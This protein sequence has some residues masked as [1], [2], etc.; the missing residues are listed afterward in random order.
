MKKVKKRSQFKMPRMMGELRRLNIEWNRLVEAARE[1]GIRRVEIPELGR[2]VRV[3]PRS[4]FQMART[5]A[6]ARVRR[7]Q[8]TIAPFYAPDL[9]SVAGLRTFG[10]EIEAI[11]PL[12]HGTSSIAHSILQEGIMCQAESLNHTTRNYWKVTTDGSVSGQGGRGLEIVSPALSGEAGFDQLRKVCSVLNRLGAKINFSCGLHVHVGRTGSTPTGMKKLVKLQVKYARIIDAFMAPSRRPGGSRYCRQVQV[13]NASLLES[14]TTLNDVAIAVGQLSIHDRYKTINFRSRQP[15][16]E[17]RQHQGT[18][19][20]HKIEMWTRFCIRAM[21][22]ME[23][24]EEIQIADAPADLNG[25]MELIGATEA[26][27]NYFNERTRWFATG[28]TSNRR[29]S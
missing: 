18:T 2:T 12:E 10:I 22:K 21:E 27:T 8:E 5:E 15:T 25:L 13:M 26:E 9:S 17:F 3:A 24:L 23:T 14:A 7:L 20:A 1:R 16:V 6:R 29:Y 28:D 11:F 19:D 4:H